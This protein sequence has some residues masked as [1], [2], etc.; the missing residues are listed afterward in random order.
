[1]LTPN[2]QQVC[3]VSAADIDNVLLR[4][5]RRELR[6]STRLTR[7]RLRVPQSQ[8]RRYASAAER[9]IEPH[10]VRRRVGARG[11]NEADAR[12]VAGR[13][14]KDEVIEQRVVWFHREP[15]A[16]HRDDVSGVS[17][18]SSR[19]YRAGGVHPT[20]ARSVVRSRLSRFSFVAVI[21]PVNMTGGTGF[22]SR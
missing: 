16:T 18:Q 6:R 20:G 3:R 10:D 19:T 17:I 13:E 7:K 4:D 11:W 22:F 12:R 5:E 21:S 9:A 8:I 14:S 1:M 2:D 15:A